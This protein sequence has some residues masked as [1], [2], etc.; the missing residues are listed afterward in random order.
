[1]KAAAFFDMDSALLEVGAQFGFLGWLMG[2][3]LGPPMSSARSAAEAGGRALGWFLGAADWRVSGFAFLRNTP[4]SRM[5]RLSRE[6][7]DEVLRFRIRRRA[8]ELVDSH[9]ERGHATVLVTSACEPLAKPVAEWL[10]FDAVLATM[11]LVSEGRYACVREL[12]EP[13]GMGKRLL[14]AR[15]CARLGIPT[16]SCHAYCGNRRDG[17]LLDLVGHPVAVNPDR[18][19][20]QVAELRGWPV[21]DLG[22]EDG[23]IQDTP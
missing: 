23:G 18:R 16:R 1:M 9:R 21:I 7:F 19:L 22:T 17:F 14:A 8:A 13:R 5:E 11:L 2:R 15:F 10:R 6:F 12:P 20:L 3:R 4:I